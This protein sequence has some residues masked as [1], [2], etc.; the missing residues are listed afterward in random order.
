MADAG[1]SVSSGLAV[2]L[3][4]TETREGK[5]ILF[6][7]PPFP[8]VLGLSFLPKLNV[9]GIPVHNDFQSMYTDQMSQAVALQRWSLH[10]LS[11]TYRIYLVLFC[12]AVF[13]GY[14]RSEFHKNMS[15][16]SFSPKTHKKSHLY[17]IQA[18]FFSLWHVSSRILKCVAI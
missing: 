14:K 16:E 10:Q 4:F 9:L 8:P 17:L 12:V 11:Y 7:P 3:G 18:I 2:L 5:N 6:S 15:S 13:D 1:S